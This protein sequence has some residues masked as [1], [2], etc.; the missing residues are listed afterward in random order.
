MQSVVLFPFFSS[1]DLCQLCLFRPLLLRPEAS[2]IQASI[3]GIQ[4]MHTTMQ[5]LVLM[6]PASFMSFPQLFVLRPE[7]Y[8]IQAY[9]LSNH[10]PQPLVSRPASSGLNVTFVNYVFFQPLVFWSV[11]QYRTELP[12]SLS[13]PDL[14]PFKSMHIASFIKPLLLM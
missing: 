9:S 14:H 7:A 4:P 8:H 5:S 10:S 12:C 2:H 3:P 1:R 6:R 13:Y 11:L